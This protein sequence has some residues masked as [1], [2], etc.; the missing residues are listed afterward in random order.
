MELIRF[1]YQ[2]IYQSRKSAYSTE[3]TNT[4]FNRLINV[5]QQKHGFVRNTHFGSQDDV[6]KI[7]DKSCRCEMMVH[8]TINNGKVVDAFNQETVEQWL[9]SNQLEICRKRD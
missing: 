8:P 1:G 9:N 7:L 6:T 5:V 2:E 3:F 4:L